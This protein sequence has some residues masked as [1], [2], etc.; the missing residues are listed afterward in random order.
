MSPSFFTLNPAKP[1]QP[2]NA[3]ESNWPVTPSALESRTTA[4]SSPDPAPYYRAT[5]AAKS[6]KRGRGQAQHPQTGRQQSYSCSSH[7]CRSS[8]QRYLQ[9]ILVLCTPCNVLDPPFL[10][11]HLN[12]TEFAFSFLQI[13]SRSEVIPSRL[14]GKRWTSF[15]W[16]SWFFKLLSSC[17]FSLIS[18][19]SGPVLSTSN[20]HPCR[21]PN[22]S[23][24]TRMLCTEQSCS[25]WPTHSPH[26][27]T[28][29][30]SSSSSGRDL[31]RHSFGQQFHPVCPHRAHQEAT[32]VRRV[33]TLWQLI[34]SSRFL[35]PS[36]P[37]R[38]Y[39]RLWLD[40]GTSGEWRA[41]RWMSTSGP[42]LLAWHLVF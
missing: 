30:T 11:W 20:S 27:N 22:Y 35:M 18:W 42:H 7:L 24:I 16:R 2:P 26:G 10:F 14:K 34:H 40:S 39:F 29:T 25:M 38:T 21:K 3:S 41:T 9:V 28:S 36:A 23:E 33:H 13:I 17:S 6:M 32:W 15:Y 5:H 19:S 12:S 37:S 8:W 31:K 4:P 1:S